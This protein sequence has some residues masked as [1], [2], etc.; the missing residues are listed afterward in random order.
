M[1][2][3]LF[4]LISSHM[5]SDF[6]GRSCWLPVITSS[7]HQFLYGAKGSSL[8]RLVGVCWTSAMAVAKSKHEQMAL[9]RISC[10]SVADNSDIWGF[11]GKMAR[12][13]P[14]LMFSIASCNLPGNTYGPHYLQR[15][16][17]WRWLW[18][19]HCDSGQAWF[20]WLVPA[21]MPHGKVSWSIPER[22]PHNQSENCWRHRGTESTEAM[23]GSMWHHSAEGFWKPGSTHF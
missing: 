14:A 20:C 3:F 15:E 22:A 1:L 21:E 2:F 5:H 16:L 9:G 23:L 17:D 4:S 12:E 6:K 19:S 8:R 18:V 13:L 11:S 7:Q 10:L